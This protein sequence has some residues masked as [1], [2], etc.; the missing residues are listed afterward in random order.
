MPIVTGVIRDPA[1]SGIRGRVTIHLVAG[2]T[3]ADPGY[4]DGGT[5]LST[6]RIVTDEDG[7]WATPL[8][9]NTDI[10][11]ANTHYEVLEKPQGSALTYRSLISVPDGAGPYALPAV[12]VADPGPVDAVAVA[13]TE[14][15]AAGGVATLDDDGQVPLDQ[16]GNVDAGGSPATTVVAGTSF[17][18][19]SAVGDDTEYARQDHAHGTPANPVTGHVAATDPHADRA[20]TD[21]QVTALSGT[22]TSALAGKASTAHA[23]THA[24]A[25]ADPVTLTQ[26][27]VTGLTAALA[28]KASTAHA[29]SHT[30]GGSDEIT[31]TQDQV[32]DLVTALAGKLATTGGRLTGDLTIGTAGQKA[33]RL[34]QS[35]GALNFEAAGTSLYVGV[36]SAVDFGGAERVY[37][38][39]ESGVE[40]AHAAGRWEFATNVEGA[41]VHAIDATT[42]VAELGAKNSLSSVRLVG[43]RATPGPPTTGT[44]TAGD[45][46]QDSRGAW[47]LCTAG[48]TPGTWT[49][50]TNVESG[51][52]SSGVITLPA[53]TPWIGVVGLSSFAIAASVGDRVTFQ[54]SFLAIL[55]G[56]NYLDSAVMVSGSPVRYGS[57]G[58]GTPATEGDPVAY[59]DVAGAIVRGLAPFTFVV[60]AGDIS[61][62]NVT[63]GVVHR[64]A[65]TTTNV[66]A[67]SAYIFRWMARNDGPA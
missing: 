63:F 5:V 21:T 14:L 45:S 65:G 36:F 33:Y 51:Y 43:R 27:Q 38:R 41:A 7:V 55:T 59:R 10:L 18:Q 48:G 37:L 28:A 1:G 49:T 66:Y 32:T 58:T 20:Y 9:P 15:G 2:D 19:A 13:V 25:G 67:S 60:E 17:G 35:G 3:G 44:W 31:L 29:T 39:L 62:G 23:G 22:L 40:L 47:H 53:S 12:L 42:G 57:S 61:G 64:G 56:V 54:A 30:D 26:A 34:R 46:A 24:A 50:G 52:V 8:V 16:L 11:P 4:T 6:T